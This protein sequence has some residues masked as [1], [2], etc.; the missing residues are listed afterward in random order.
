MSK[1]FDKANKYLSKCDWKDV[2]LLKFCLFSMGIIAGTH[3]S[4]ENKKAT[5]LIA[6]IVFII[7]YIPLM[8][9]FIPILFEKEN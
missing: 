3:V 8:E 1:L 2:A 4:R 9:K 5:N 7:T 6:A